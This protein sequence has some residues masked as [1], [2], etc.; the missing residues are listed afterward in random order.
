MD[1]VTS[2]GPRDS[3]GSRYPTQPR[4]RYPNERT[5]STNKLRGKGHGEK[6]D[7]V[8]ELREMC[9]TLAFFSPAKW[10]ATL[11]RGNLS[12]D[13]CCTRSRERKVTNSDGAHC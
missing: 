7:M 2:S 12:P 3:V 10:C 5:C 13:L 8:F 11:K 9:E 6:G 4:Q 1:G